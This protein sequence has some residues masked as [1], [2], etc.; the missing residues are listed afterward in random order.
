[1]KNLTVFI[2]EETEASY[3]RKFVSSDVCLKKYIWKSKKKKKEK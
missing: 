2:F 3:E 1:M